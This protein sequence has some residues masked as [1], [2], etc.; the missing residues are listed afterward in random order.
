MAERRQLPTI[1]IKPREMPFDQII[2]VKGRN[3]IGEALPMY[4]KVLSDAMVQRAKLIKMGQQTAA[5]EKAMGATP[6]SLNGMDPEQGMQF[7]KMQNDI[8]LQ[9][10]KQQREQE[11]QT[12]SVFVSEFK[13]NPEPYLQ[14]EQGGGKLNFINDL[15]EGGRDQNVIRRDRG[16]RWQITNGFKYE[17]G[18]SSLYTNLQDANR[19]QGLLTQN[20]PIADNA[21]R[22]YI[23]KQVQGG[24]V[25]SNQDI[26]ELGGSKSI[27]DRTNQIIAEKSSGRLSDANREY[28][29]KLTEK[30]KSGALKNLDLAARQYVNK[31]VDDVDVL[32][33]GGREELY[34]KLMSDVMVGGFDQTGNYVP[35]KFKSEP[36]ANVNTSNG[37]GVQS[38]PPSVGE[39]FNGQKV[40]GVRRVR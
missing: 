14:F 1:N 36:G 22:F 2:A 35:G 40:I 18:V 4:G 29:N 7:A 30:L 5:I 15:S 39:T 27:L 34:N 28:Y 17:P 23:A 20:N 32:F 21:V 16:L 9:E 8:R 10:L 25:L 33:P 13:K 3:P 26:Q 31:N 24:G 38:A 37:Q 6:G 19:V 11:R 12:R